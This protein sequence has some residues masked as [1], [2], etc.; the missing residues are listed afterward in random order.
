MVVAQG[1]PQVQSVTLLVS[2]VLPE[3]F[4][5]VV[6]PSVLLVSVEPPVVEPG[7][8]L[9]GVVAAPVVWMLILLKVEMTELSL[10]APEH[11]PWCN[12]V[13]SPPQLLSTITMRF[14][15]SVMLDR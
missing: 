2:V 11:C 8:E 15:S 10:Q 5:S 14:I 7:S 13:I 6:E 4:G 3:L 1:S 12:Q 9:D